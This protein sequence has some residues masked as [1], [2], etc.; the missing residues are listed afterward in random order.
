MKKIKLSK[1]IVIL[2]TCIWVLIGIF[3]IFWMIS[4]A[5]KDNAEV[6]EVPPKLLPTARN[7]LYFHLDYSNTE[8]NE[9]ALTKKIEFD[10]V[11][12]LIGCP[13][14][15]SNIKNSGAYIYATY[16]DRKIAES[17]MVSYER[18][19]AVLQTKTYVVKAVSKAFE[20]NQDE[21]FA[22]TNTKFFFESEVKYGLDNALSN[23]T[24]DQ[25]LDFYTKYGLEG[26]MRSVG[27]KKSALR[28]F[29]NF[30]SAWSITAKSLLGVD[31]GFG[32]FI[33]NSVIVTFCGI[34]GALI[35]SSLA[36]YSLSKL[37]KRRL[38]SFIILLYLG[39]IMI[40]SIITLIPTYELFNTMGLLNHLVSLFLGFWFAPLTVYFFK[41][42]FDALPKEMIESAKIDGASDIKVFI[43][44]VVPLSKSVFSAMTIMSFIPI[45]N[46]FLWPFLIIQEPA[47]FTYAVALYRMTQHLNSVPNQA[48]A[49]S[50]IAAIPTTIIFSL[51][52]KTIQKG[53]VFSG[54]KG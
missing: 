43:S 32:Q 34:T 40:P 30:I 3:P 7:E 54:I 20:R 10:F 37:M 48:M 14:Q 33:L 21:L 27:M 25:I 2:L 1:V 5:T 16:G 24:T 28:I 49:L 35:L 19:N 42:F 53:I 15:F 22:Y 47:K 44:I 11:N 18:N 9:E 6:F 29:D 52:Q 36:A 41:G 4:S 46:D 39:T 12:V 38:A 26:E 13:M 8:W 23:K 17:H 51:F 45:W 31:L 50:C